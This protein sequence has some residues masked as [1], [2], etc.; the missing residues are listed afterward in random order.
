VNACAWVI[1]TN[2]ASSIASSAGAGHWDDFNFL[3]EPSAINQ[4]K[5]ELPEQ[6][7]AR[8]VRTNRPTWRSLRDLRESAL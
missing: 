5:W 7:S 1:L 2:A 3:L 6:K 4:D 8:R